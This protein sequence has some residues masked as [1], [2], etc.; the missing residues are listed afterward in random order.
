MIQR[1][2]GASHKI[3]KG[4]GSRQIIILEQGAPKILKRSMEHRKILKRSKEQEKNP[5]ARLKIKMEQG[6][7]EK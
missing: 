5:G 4:A 2:K 6:A 3:G 7:Q 1:S